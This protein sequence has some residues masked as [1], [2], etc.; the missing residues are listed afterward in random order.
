[1]QT[2]TNHQQN[3]DGGDDVASAFKGSADVRDEGLRAAA[4]A[5]PD[6]GDSSSTDNQHDEK[7][8]GLRGAGGD[9]IDGNEVETN[10]SERVS[11]HPTHSVCTRFPPAVWLMCAS[12]WIAAH[13]SRPLVKHEQ[14]VQPLTYDPP[15][16]HPHPFLTH[17]SSPTSAPT[18]LPPPPSLVAPLRTSHPSLRSAPPH[19]PSRSRRSTSSSSERTSSAASTPT[20]SRNR[21]RYSRWASSPS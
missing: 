19:P 2:T 21:R 4:H 11:T 3:D 18:H 12:K 5:A 8:Q 1:M 14:R 15:Y 10:W 20:T 17:L 13:G 6:G 9:D 16:P 7:P